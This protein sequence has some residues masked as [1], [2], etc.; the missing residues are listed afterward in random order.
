MADANTAVATATAG[1]AAPKEQQPVQEVVLAGKFKGSTPEDAAAQ[2][3]KGLRELHASQGLVPLAEGDLIGEGKPFKTVA[4][5]ERAYKSAERLVG[6]PKE[7][8]KP[9]STPMFPKEEQKEPDTSKPVDTAKVLKDAGFSGDDLYRMHKANALGDSVVDK[10]ALAHDDFKGLPPRTR[11]PA[12][13]ALLKEEFGKVEAN[14][15]RAAEV[16]GGADKLAE[17]GKNWESYVPPEEHARIVRLMSNHETFDAAALLL[18]QHHTRKYGGSTGPKPINGSAPG[19]A[20]DDEVRKAKL[21]A[22][23]RIAAG[24]GTA[25]D[26]ALFRKG[27]K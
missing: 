10:L 18:Q 14:E 13:R 17:L 6:K 4:D 5:A 16:V 25:S 23:A 19:P 15:R 20:S 27:N 3:V 24:Q 1:D 11:I 26:F 7:D 22:T 9:I 2:L 21:D 12:M 8:A